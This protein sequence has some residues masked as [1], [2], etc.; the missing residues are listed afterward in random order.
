MIKPV[1]WWRQRQARRR[2]MPR[3]RSHSAAR[4]T[5]VAVIALIVIVAVAALLEM[6]RG[7]GADLDLIEYARENRLDPVEL[8]QVAGR[9]RRLIVIADVSSAAAPKQFAANAVE[10]LAASTGVDI[11]ALDIPSDEQP[12]IDRYLA[13][14]PEDASILLGRS[15]AIR[16]GDGASRALLDLYRTVWRVNQELG[17][18]RRI[19]IVAIDHPAWPPARAMSPSA[20]AQ[21]YGQRAEHMIST[22]QERTLARNPNARILF[23]VDG[24]NALKTGGARVQTG[25]A[26]PIDV[27]WLAAQ[28]AR[29]YPQSVYSIL[30]DATPTRVITPDVAAYRGTVAG[31][32]IRRAG[33]GSGFALRVG[34]PF[35]A[36]ARRPIRIIGTTGI[37]FEIMPRDEPFTSLADAWV[38]LGN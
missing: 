38:F 30:V 10:A 24:L 20:A 3:T 22:I 19:R 2:F 12:F 7:S 25:G 23:L 21:L 36:I 37:E 6:R 4:T 28:L 27:E 5:T 26:R 15:R 35:D 9:A 13:T 34:Q 8:V 31:D 14:A 1:E 29:R 17:A 11:V 16:E 18:A 32:V 33:L